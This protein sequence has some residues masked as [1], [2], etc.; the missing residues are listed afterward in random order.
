[1]LGEQTEEGGGGQAGQ[2]REAAGEFGAEEH[3]KGLG[4]DRW[5]DDQMVAGGMTSEE[6]TPAAFSID[7]GAQDDDGVGNDPHGCFAR[8]S[9]RAARTASSIQALISSSE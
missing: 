5:G 6:T 8:R 4:N 9:A 7:V 2:G 1:R 3:V